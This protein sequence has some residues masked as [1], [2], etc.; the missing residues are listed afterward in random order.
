MV[1]NVIITYID[2]PLRVK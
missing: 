2:G 1:Y